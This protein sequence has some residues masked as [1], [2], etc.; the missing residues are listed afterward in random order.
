MNA[1]LTYLILSLLQL[2]LAAYHH[3]SIPAEILLTSCP[4]HDRSSTSLDIAKEEPHPAPAI[5]VVNYQA[6]H[7]LVL[8]SVHPN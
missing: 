8:V 1:Y 3:C 4:V 2:T 5:L 6:V 7:S